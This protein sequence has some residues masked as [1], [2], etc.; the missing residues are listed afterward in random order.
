MYFSTY[1]ESCVLHGIATPKQAMSRV[2]S[3]GT[4]I[5]CILRDV[6]GYEQ[7]EHRSIDILLRFTSLKCTYYLSSSRTEQNHGAR[8]QFW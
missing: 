1:P 5:L 7:G 8:G 4:S 3:S 2:S 6:F